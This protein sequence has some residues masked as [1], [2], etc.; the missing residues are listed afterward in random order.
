MSNKQKLHR[1]CLSGRLESSHK[2]LVAGHRT[3]LGHSLWLWCCK[4]H[5]KQRYRQLYHAG[6]S[7]GSRQA[8]PMNGGTTSDRPRRVNTA[9]CQYTQS[10]VHTRSGG[11]SALTRSRKAVTR[12]P[13]P[14]QP[15]NGGL[16]GPGHGPAV[17]PNGA[18][19]NSLPV[20]GKAGERRSKTGLFK[21]KTEQCESH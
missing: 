7:A 11:T 6:R 8:L 12:L 5:F 15:V 14:R 10:R 20:G 13:R 9:V 18:A 19:K 17:P 16:Q 3:A 1:A 4:V 2:C 21:R